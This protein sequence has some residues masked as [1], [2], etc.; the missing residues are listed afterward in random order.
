MG[1]IPA[2]GG[3]PISLA[4]PYVAAAADGALVNRVRS[5]R[6]EPGT[7][8]RELEALIAGELD[9]PAECVIA[10]R[11]CT[12]AIHAA[13]RYLE[14]GVLGKPLDA[15]CL[16]Y[17][18]TYRWRPHVRLVD[19]D[20]DGWPVESVGVTVDLWGRPAPRQGVIVDAAHNFL[21]SAHSSLMRCAG[22]RFLCYSFAP[23][24]QLPCFLGGA[25]VCAYWEDAETIRHRLRNDRYKASEDLRYTGGRE[26][27]PDP[28]AAMLLEQFSGYHPAQARRH[29]LLQCYREA[30]CDYPWWEIMTLPNKCSG[31]LMVLRFQSARLREEAAFALKLNNIETAVHFPVAMRFRRAYALSQKILS[32][33]L[34]TSLAFADIERIA[35]IILGATD[36]FTREVARPQGLA[37]CEA[38]DAGSSRRHASGIAPACP[39][40]GRRGGEP[41]TAADP[42]SGAL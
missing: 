30:L 19:T 26:L 13:A 23:Q 1:R 5:T 15:T 25:L 9:L 14:E 24:K 32:L 40:L 8:V 28:V 27:M 21:H 20:E 42:E 35:R 16:T 36:R 41:R 2:P 39:S 18:G 3:A 6:W 33:P 38:R 10:T 31:H 12:A 7:A 29:Y 11:S 4:R 34:H 17:A 22:R 37:A